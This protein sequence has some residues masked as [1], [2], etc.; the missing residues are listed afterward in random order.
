MP[1]FLI[2]FAFQTLVHA[3]EIMHTGIELVKQ[4]GNVNK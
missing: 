2:A 3:S 1:F 4:L